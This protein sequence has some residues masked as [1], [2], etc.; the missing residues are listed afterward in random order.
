MKRVQ[1]RKKK[2]GRKKDLQSSGLYHHTTVQPAS[3]PS[4]SPFGPL[5]PHPSDNSDSGTRVPSGHRR[6]G[7]RRTWRVRVAGLQADDA[8]T[9]VLYASRLVAIFCGNLSSAAVVGVPSPLPSVQHILHGRLSS[10][11]KIHISHVHLPPQRH[12]PRRLLFLPPPALRGSHKNPPPRKLLSR[13]S[14]PRPSPTCTDPA[15]RL[16]TRDLQLMFKEW[17]NDKGGYRIKWLDDTNALVVFA[18]A[19]VGV[20]GFILFVVSEAKARYSQLNAL[21]CP[22][23]STP[24]HPSLAV[25]DPTIGPTQLKLS[26]HSLPGRSVT[27]LP[28]QTPLTAVALLSPSQPTTTWPHPKC[29]AEQ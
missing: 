5:P 26:S 20:S 24:L 27:V 29:T 3:Q 15:C 13:A 6:F 2:E 25:S 11:L 16:K 17:D 1:V 12:A 8:R 18:D 22:S 9:F 21:T 14:I 19:N 4:H 23:F 7:V 28:C 10:P